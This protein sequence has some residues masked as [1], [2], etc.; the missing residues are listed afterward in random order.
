MKRLLPLL[1]AVAGL[2]ACLHRNRLNVECQWTGDPG[3]SLDLTGRNDQWH[4]IRDVEIAEELGIRYGDS[5]R[6]RDGILEEHRRTA[7]CTASLFARIASVH[8]I[9]VNDVVSERGRRPP[10]VDL[11]VLLSFAVFYWLASRYLASG[12]FNRMAVDPVLPATVA[13]AV[14]SGLV[15]A[16]GVLALTAWGTVVEIFRVG[17]G[18]G[19]YRVG[20]LP[21]GHHLEGL[22]IS[23]VFL[24]VLV[25]SLEIT[26]RR[27]QAM[28]RISAA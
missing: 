11:A 7:A 18:H 19:S 15:S 22:F 5:F 26:R 27:R 28:V 2:S 4:L 24:F 21:W 3:S 25:A 1:L 16:T 23:G 14:M 8:G 17:N 9:S 20:R 12:L 10:G 13:T 6:R